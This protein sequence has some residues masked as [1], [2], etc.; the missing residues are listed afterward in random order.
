MDQVLQPRPGTGRRRLYL[1]I[2]AAFV[3][4]I[5]V[6]LSLSHAVAF[7]FTRQVVRRE[8]A[9]AHAQLARTLRDNFEGRLAN[10]FGA[11]RE[12]AT[13]DSVRLLL[14]A[15]SG[16]DRVEPMLDLSRKIVRIRIANDFVEQIFLVAG[17][18]D[19]VFY[20][21]LYDRRMFY[22]DYFP[23]RDA[24]FWQ[25]EYSFAVMTARVR[26]YLHDMDRRRELERI[27]ILHTFPFHRGR[28]P[29]LQCVIMLDSRSLERFFRLAH[30]LPGADAVVLGRDRQVIYAT[31]GDLAAFAAE[32]LERGH[33]AW[34]GTEY[35]ASTVHSDLGLTYSAVVA[36]SVAF[37]TSSAMWR[38]F[39][40]NL[41]V[42]ALVGLALS[43]LLTRWLY[44]PI[45]HMLEFVRGTHTDAPRVETDETG[46]VEMSFL[47]LL[48]K[49]R[50]LRE[51][52][53]SNR[54]VV[55]ERFCFR[56]LMGLI[57]DRREMRQW[58]SRAR[59]SFARREFFAVRVRI[60][61]G[62]GLSDGD[63]YLYRSR[64]VD[65]LKGIE[66][67]LPGTLLAQVAD[68]AVGIAG[69]CASG[70][71]TELQS[72]R[73]LL[74]AIAKGYE[75]HLRVAVGIGGVVDTLEGIASSFA[76]ASSALNYCRP[77]VGCQIVEHA[78]VRPPAPIVYYPL[79]TEETIIRSLM[80]CDARTPSALVQ[81]I[82]ERNLMSDVTYAQLE[83]LRV[84]LVMT[85]GRVLDKLERR[86]GG[87]P[88]LR[89]ELAR[90]RDRDDPTSMSE[91]IGALF[92]A[93][94][95]LIEQRGRV[96]PKEQL[97]RGY[98]DA[99]LSR[100]LGLDEVSDR[101]GLTSSY[102]SRYFKRHYGLNFVDYVNRARIREARRLLRE[103][104]MRV[105]DI[106][107]KVGFRSANTLCRVFRRYEGTSP[108]EYRDGR[109]AEEIGAASHRADNYERSVPATARLG[110]GG[111]QCVQ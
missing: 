58:I 82:V 81:Q 76:Q 52:L 50:S 24:T 88:G 90:I 9:S 55:R 23:G 31:N 28:E 7:L 86:Y 32:R 75:K 49:N 8:A 72:L 20:E 108:T 89:A 4:V 67:R 101:F 48:R 61:R 83:E 78:R 77:L 60:D 5:I 34:R 91:C 79:D 111:I 110:R 10:V 30:V 62:A 11:V 19:S 59:F 102:V 15:S 73:G 65:E 97:I 47:S 56:L 57:K 96:S 100:D 25:R 13:D 2:L 6:P 21:G 3:V 40:L 92:A 43:Y 74:I 63:L 42:F 37:A 36:E 64:L 87:L 95:A 106:A 33:F 93:I 66:R 54:G 26:S 1:N 84:A 29:R 69:G 107:F 27:V 35:V 41:V 12:L 85:I 80:D 16:C 45:R 68:N 94:C 99:N 44:R 109:G 18:L 71:R 17:E 104:D 46:Y 105:A 39:V 22:R 38:Q 98:V 70:S 51:Q 103:T 53:Q 14:D